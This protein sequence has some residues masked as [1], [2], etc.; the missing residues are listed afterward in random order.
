ML[1]SVNIRSRVAVYTQIENEIQFAIASGRLKGGE[2]LPSTMELGERFGI[3]FNTVGKAY[4]DLE[5]M[6][7]VRTW[8]GRGVFVN[9]GVAADCA[10]KCRRDIV[11]RMHEVAL[12]AKAV[13]RKCLASDAGPYGQ[14]P[15]EI[16]AL[17]KAKRGKK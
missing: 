7:F 10:R 16:L 4:R 13:V 17:A 12:E 6:G 15:P 14:T 2:Q 3:N 5:M 11:A 8:R 9:E 1:A